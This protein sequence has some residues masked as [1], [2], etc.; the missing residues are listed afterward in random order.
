[1]L[2][3]MTI[4]VFQAL[5]SVRHWRDG[6]W[7]APLIMLAISVLSVASAVS[8]GPE[9]LETA[10][11]SL[12]RDLLVAAPFVAGGMVI[13]TH[14][15]E[16]EEQ[17]TNMALTDQ[18]TGLKNRHAF[19]TETRAALASGVTGT[20]AICDADHFKRIND[21]YGHA[22]GDIGLCHIA[23]HL[24]DVV[25]EHATLARIGGEEFG[26]FIPDAPGRPSAAL[27]TDAWTEP[28]SFNLPNIAER[29]W[30]ITL[31]VGSCKT[32]PGA[33]LKDLMRHADMAL[34]QAKEMGRAR[35]VVWSSQITKPETLPS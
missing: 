27:V 7:K 33:R 25:P 17:L 29:R 23:Q 34:Y 19:F 6:F 8:I 21:T 20:L 1:M 4:I 5:F 35:H 11:R 31:S 13:V 12:P 32:R 18:L 10:L 26:V 9:T 2:K 15:S 24:M 22:A 16:L 30:Q 14:L 3:R 28:I